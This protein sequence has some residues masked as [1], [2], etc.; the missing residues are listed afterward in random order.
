MSHV[1]V[2]GQ[3]G[4]LS[5]LLMS[6][7]GCIRQSVLALGHVFGTKPIA[8]GIVTE[9]PID[10]I[11]PFT[12]YDGL[13]RR[14]SKETGRNVVAQPC[15]PFQ[16]ESYLES[17][18]YQFAVVTPAQYARLSNRDALTVVAAPKDSEERL[19]RAALLLV[20][21]D[22]D[23]HEVTQLRNKLIAFGPSGNSRTHIA[24]LELLKEHGIG[25]DAIKTDMLPIPGSLRHVADARA[26]VRS[27][28]SGGSDAGFIDEADWQTSAEAANSTSIASPERFRVIGRTIALPDAL[29]VASPKTPQEVIDQVRRFLI[30]ASQDNMDVLEPLKISGYVHVSDDL[31]RA[32]EALA[33]PSN[34]GN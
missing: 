22:S 21:S 10:M 33:G 4:L 9:N 18:F 3:I 25:R 16:V 26:I 19:A 32:C 20:A 8:I 28:A 17:G 30:A 14:L 2:A 31:I 5:V 11:V 6:Q 23:Y 15:A 24:A 29:I 27:V 34:R 1:R 13:C 12:A 7:S